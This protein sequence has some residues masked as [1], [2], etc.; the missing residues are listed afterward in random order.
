MVRRTLLGLFFCILPAALPAQAGQFLEAPQYPVGTNPSAVAVGYFNND[1]IPDIAVANYGSS[2]V[3]IFLGNADGT[4]TRANCTASA[5]D[6]VTGGSPKGVVTGDFNGD[7]YTDIAVTNSGS[8]TVSVL[9]G[10]GDGT[11][12]TK[13]DFSTGT[14]PWGIATGDFGNGAHDLAVTN[15]GSGTVSVLLFGNTTATWQS[16]Y[17]KYTYTTGLNPSSI[18][19]GDVN[20][21]GILDLVVANDNNN[22]L[23]SVLLGLGTGGVGNGQFQTQVQY[24][25]GNTPVSVALADLM[26][27]GTLDIVTADYG[28]NTVSILFNDPTKPG[29]FSGLTQYPV[30][31]FPTSV[32]VGDFNGDGI[33][34]LAVSNGQGNTVTVL[35][36]VGGGLFQG[37]V[38]VGTGDNPYA[39]AV[40]KVPGN[41]IPEIVA[42]NNGSNSIGVLLSNGT[43]DTFQ[44]RA[45][46]GAS[47]DPYCITSADFNGDGIPDLAVGSYSAGTISIELGNGDGTFQS[48]LSTTYSAATPR[49]MVT[50]DFNGDGIPDLAIVNYDSNTVT[51]LLGEPG[52]TFSPALGSP[53][54]VGNEP[55]AI[56]V[57][58]FNGDGIPDLAVAN[59]GGSGTGT[60]TVSV[61]LGNG[62][63]GKGDGTFAPAINST[64]G[65]GP[66]SL[67]TAYLSG[68]GH[69]DLVVANEN[70]TT[71]SVLI[72]NNNGTFSA[73]QTPPT[74]GKNAISVVAGNFGGNG[75]PDLAVAFSQSQEISVLIGNGDGT[76]G[77]A[78][79]YAIGTYPSSM[80][81]A[82]FNGDGKP[83]IAVIGTPSSAYPGNVVSLLLGNGDGTFGTPT[84]FD[85]GYQPTFAAVNDFSGDGAYDLAVANSGSNSVSVLLNT[86]GTI[87]RTVS[88][89]SPSTFGQ[90]VTLTTTIAPGTGNGTVPS[91]TVTIT[92]AGV[93]LGSGPLVDGVFSVNTRTLPVG[94]DSISTAY[95]GDS[96]YQPHTTSFT[97]TVQKAATS[98]QLTSTPAS[99]NLGQT[100]TLTAAVIFE[101]AVAPTG[102]MTFLDGTTQ[103]GTTVL[104]ESGIATFTTSALTAGTHSITA[105]YSG[106]GNYLAGS[107]PVFNLAVAAPGFTLSTSPASLSIDV[108]ASATATIK[109]SPSGGLNPS[110]VAL[111][112]SIAPAAT[113]AP[114]CSVG[115]ITVA[116]NVGSSTLTVTA[117]GSQAKLDF[118]PNSGGLFA[119][120]LAIPAILL[121]GAGFKK[122]SGRKILGFCLIVL[123]LAACCFEVACSSAGQATSTSSGTHPSTGSSGTP[124][125]AYTITITGTSN[126]VQTQTT[127]I[128]LTV[129]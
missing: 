63:N 78:T 79:P 52:G 68:S 84:L 120:G 81:S 13:L 55:D 7:G 62:T 125:G 56:V 106:D 14:A 40:D 67:A 126:E 105:A 9:L 58:D 46:F 88:S 102:S 30:G 114:T 60:G 11:F 129:Q 44:S 22:N 19:L 86:Q 91:G 110:Q 127:T 111:T 115:S 104:N 37:Q 29:T 122:T 15:S 94:T 71:L 97:Q 119:I 12:Q 10:N 21:D 99:P 70:A 27:D 123:V 16:G 65:A 95:S 87:M 108:G 101:A 47:V 50:T 31:I 77:T 75:F 45:D 34:D 59:Y 6:C 32:A 48:P 112:C 73:Q 41:S 96:N 128:S 17:K 89:S 100:M 5:I 43:K 76:F 64:V 124:A 26:G 107:S 118:F 116:N 1:D 61:L 24:L 25:T 57:G 92:S 4:F 36:G 85:V 38:N 90:S 2:T 23:V 51:I 98:I 83:D 74:V 109:I 121:S 8:G 33:L 54:A 93:T 28:G 80:V 117:A 20:N 69:L 49:A 35:W 18:A 82:D 103:L 53:I 113:P 42:A 3:S 66:V 39:I 72:G